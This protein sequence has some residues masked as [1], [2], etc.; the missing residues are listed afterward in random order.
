[1]HLF[2]KFDLLYIAFRCILFFSNQREKWAMK[3]G[4]I[5]KTK[6]KKENNNKKNNF[7]R[8]LNSLDCLFDDLIVVHQLPY[9]WRA[10]NS[11]M[12]QFCRNKWNRTRDYVLSLM[13]KWNMKPS[14]VLIAHIIWIGFSTFF[15]IFLHLFMFRPYIHR[16]TC[17][18]DHYIYVNE[19]G[20]K[21]QNIIRMLNAVEWY[22]WWAYVTVN[23]K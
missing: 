2:R 3:I 14:Y 7:H 19:F 18:K 12:R 10:T 1:M 17:I 22:I 6:R 11:Q 13:L 5:G 9:W 21:H 23:I 8:E 4:K 16:I 20:G 15:I